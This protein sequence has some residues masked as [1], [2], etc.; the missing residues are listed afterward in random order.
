MPQTPDRFPG[1]R[2][3]EELQLEDTAANPS[4]AGGMT[5]NAGSFAFEDSL[6]VFNPRTGGSGIDEAQHR[7]LDQLV[8]GIAED[9][10]L[11]VVRSGDQV[12]DVIYWTDNGKTD[13]IRETTIT[14][15]SGKVSVVTI[16]QYESDGSTVAET[17]TGTV[18]RASGKVS[19]IDWVL[20]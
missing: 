13:K 15:A 1:T 3:E 5:Y 20:T 14:R 18:T 4:A 8:H 2:Q 17:L 6:G 11:E 9:S 12:T 10:F 19:S 16:K 7:A